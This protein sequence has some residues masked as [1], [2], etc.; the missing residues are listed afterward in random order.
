MTAGALVLNLS[1]ELSGVILCAMGILLVVFSKVD[2]RT[3]QY[4]ILLYSGLIV[5]TVSNMAGL[6]MRGLP[7]PFWRAALY[8]SNFT[9]FLMP[10]VLTYIITCYLFS[11]VDPE[12]EKRRLRI[13]IRALLAFD[14]VLLII[15]QF[16]GLYYILD[17]NNIY[18]RSA[19]YPVAYLPIIIMLG[20]DISMLL[21][22]GN[23]LKKKERITFWIYLTL[24]TIATVLQIIQYG[25]NFAIFSTIVAG[26]ALF[27]FIIK[28]QTERYYRQELENE[29]LKTEI[30]L[31]QI[32]PHFLYNAL[33]AIKHAC[34]TDP[35]RARDAIDQFSAYLRHNMDTLKVDQPIPFEQ[36]LEHV[37]C[38]LELQKFRFGAELNVA[39]DLECMDFCLPTLTLQPIVEN[40]VTYGV[41]KQKA[42]PGLV[43]VR[44]REYPDRYEVTVID[45]GPGFIPDTVPGD[46]ERSHVGIQNVRERLRQVSAGELRIDSV[47]GEG[48]SVNIL[49]PKNKLQGKEGKAANDDFRH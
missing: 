4:F 35:M 3:R 5:F 6:L 12:R 36:E 24:P 31:A 28:D 25:I 48:T 10:M 32:Q 2:K 45:N 26:L 22:H 33:G 20:I 9:E 43:T 38:Y 40:A 39:Y 23:A 15:S 44:S 18:Q 19:A 16:T 8:V 27:I 49:L 17:E 14:I 11:I 21:R 41:R 34:L 47:L 13:L 1:I 30:L 7:G 42:H 37:K 46:S 29:K